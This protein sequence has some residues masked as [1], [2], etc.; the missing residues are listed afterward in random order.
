[1]QLLGF[2]HGFIFSRF[3]EQLPGSAEVK[4]FYDASDEPSLFDVQG[5]MD[6]G[7]VCSFRQNR[8]NKADRT[9]I[10]HLG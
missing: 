4:G 2:S 10:F 5:L 7:D 8:T 6:G 3:L 9:H 1:M